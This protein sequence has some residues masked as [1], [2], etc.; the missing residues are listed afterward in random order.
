MTAPPTPRKA[1]SGPFA[2]RL[3]ALLAKGAAL[4][5][6]SLLCAIMVTLL[7]GAGYVVGGLE[8]LRY[9]RATTTLERSVAELSAPPASLEQWLEQLDPSLRNA[10][11]LRI[12]GQRVALPGPAL[13]PYLVG[14]LVL[15][16][17]LGTLLGMMAML[18]GTGLALE[19]ATDLQAI[20]D[21]LA[22][23]VKGLGFAF[24]TSIAGVATSAMLGLLSA[25]MLPFQSWRPVDLRTLG[26]MALGAAFLCSAFLLLIGGLRLGEISLLA[27][28]RYTG[29]LFA[30]LL[31]YL[32]WNHVPDVGGFTGSALLLASGLLVLQGERHRHRAQP[33]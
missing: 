31:G 22:A 5:T 30:V 4:L 25:L 13:T 11:R 2:D 17:M 33:R 20:R 19:T 1:R 9:R 16:G 6:L 28:F 14:L 3:F 18:R 32:V 29:L 10:T 23:P 7:I 12:E 15:L 8:L 27:P 21:S 26:L 24:G